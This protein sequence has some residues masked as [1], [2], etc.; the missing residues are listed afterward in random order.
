MSLL[1]LAGHLELCDHP[2]SKM[3]PWLLAH[4]EEY[5]T[6]EHCT[7]P[8]YRLAI[9]NCVTPLQAAVAAIQQDGISLGPSTCQ[10]TCHANSLQT[11][12]L[13]GWEHRS[14]I[15]HVPACGLDL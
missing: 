8:C 6:G 4:W 1:M 5:H 10:Q 3:G 13:L 2:A 9:W 12:V 11:A 14:P 15:Q 7:S